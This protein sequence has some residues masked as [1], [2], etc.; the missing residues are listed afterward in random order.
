ME[1]GWVPG[2]HPHELDVALL[3][4]AP[5]CH[6]DPFSHHLSLLTNVLSLKMVREENVG[7]F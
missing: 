3:P 6:Q 7:E 4:A 5:F 1:F 2:L